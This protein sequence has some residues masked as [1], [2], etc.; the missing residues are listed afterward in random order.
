MRQ[1]S[2]YFSVT[3]NRVE[4]P[5]C[6]VLPQE[7]SLYIYRIIRIV[8]DRF[9][10]LWIDMC[11]KYSTIIFTLQNKSLRLFLTLCSSSVSGPSSGQ[12]DADDLEP[13]LGGG[14]P[15]QA[16]PPQQ[17][18]TPAGGEIPGAVQPGNQ[19]LGETESAWWVY[20]AREQG[21]R[22]WDRMPGNTWVRRS[23]VLVVR[24]LVHV[25]WSMGKYVSAESEEKNFSN[26]CL[27]VTSWLSL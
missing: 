19:M 23:V 2:F 12:G 18:Q 3:E 21:A 5:V 24:S 6:E 25:G 20:S 10:F 17:R 7:H 15:R 14:E 11:S 1:Y 9:S 8:P 4:N 26:F 22:R 16:T 13:E 27:T